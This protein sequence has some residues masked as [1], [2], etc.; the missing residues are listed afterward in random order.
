M[1]DLSRTEYLIGK[2]KL[3]LLKK[4]KVLLCGV[5]GVGSFVAEGLCRSGLGELDIVDYDKIDPSNINRQIMV[6][7]NNIGEIKVEAL[8]KRLELISDTKITAYNTFIDENFMIEKDYD[9]IVDCIDTLTS[10]FILVKKAK[11]KNIRIIS[12][13]GSASRIDPSNIKLTTLD[14]TRN[15]PLAKRF[16][17]LVKKEGF[18]DKIE[19]VYIDSLPVKTNIIQE[20]KTNKERYPLGSLIFVTASVGLYIGKIIFERLIEDEI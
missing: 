20:G 8:K 14:K 4:K 13:L 18:K 9:Y 5:G 3:E 12:A 15:D 11:E 16:R 7:K 19:V 2:D 10:K 6:D 17:N 1:V